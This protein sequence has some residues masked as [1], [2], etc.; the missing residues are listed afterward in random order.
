[1]NLNN[2]LQSKCQK[3]DDSGFTLMEVIVSMSIFVLVV[4]A[5]LSIYSA[6]L[7]AGQKTTT[8]IRI[9]QEAQIIMSLLAKKIR[10]SRVNYSYTGYSS[11]S[12]PEETLALIDL[13]DDEYY[14]KNIDSALAVAINPGDPED[15]EDYNMI[16]A[17][18]VSITDLEFYI[19]P[20]SN[21]FLS[22]DTPPSSQPYVT[23]VI[24]L[25][26]I[27]GQANESL[28]I[29]QTIPQRSGGVID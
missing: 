20:T 23:I 26:S 7:R 18:N 22:L 4:T 13:L 27:K 9:Q 1:M 15:D 2:T 17:S 10:M 11:I 8:L 25:T 6:T 29:Q 16:P 21:P 24:T 28:V 12:N 19:S 5:S 3:Q 14:F